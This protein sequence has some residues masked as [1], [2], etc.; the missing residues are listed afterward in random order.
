MRRFRGENLFIQMNFSSSPDPD[1]TLG[2]LSVDPGETL[3]V[4]NVSENN[5]PFCNFQLDIIFWVLNGIVGAAILLGNSFACAVFLSRSLLRQN[6]MNIYL[7]GLSIADISMA[8]LVVPGFA[9]FCSGCTHKWS[10]YCWLFGGA[11]DIAFPATVLNLLA[12]T[13][14]RYLAVIRP[15]HYASTM[16]KR[17]VF[18]ILL[19][20]WVTPLVVSSVRSIWQHSWDQQAVKNAEIVYNAILSTMFGF[21]PIPV[22]FIVNL[23]IMRAI[24][25]HGRRIHVERAECMSFS[26]AELG[27]TSGFNE[28]FTSSVAINEQN[29]RNTYRR[30]KGTMSCV[31]VVLIFIISWLPRAFL[32][33]CSLFG[34]RDLTSPLLVKLS[35]FF[36][37]FQSS[38]NPA[39]Y[40]FYRNDFRQA[41]RRLIKRQCKCANQ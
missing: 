2:N 14:D 33:I 16:T 26:N 7:I 1:S 13:Y 32:N 15:L 38:V 19:A 40:S 31:L 27:P 39:I 35:L 3:Q 28:D 36:L 12:I 34:R 25:S 22:L 24:K 23:K 4:Q 30:R 9:A 17:K 8:V 41:A 11:R 6:Y 21:L 18:S 29:R 5:T 37:F 10:K 20:V